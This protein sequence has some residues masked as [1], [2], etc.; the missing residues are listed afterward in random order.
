LW[1]IAGAA[2]PA[3]QGFNFG[4]AATARGAI[5]A[6][7][8]VDP[9][10]PIHDKAALP[11]YSDGDTNNLVA[12]NTTLQSGRQVNLVATAMT[13][14]AT[15]TLINTTAVSERL[16]TGEQPSGLNL[17]VHDSPISL[18]IFLGPQIANHTSPSGMIDDFCFVPV[19]L[20]LKA[21]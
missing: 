12:G 21:P 10:A 19:T 4:A 13:D 2:E 14:H 6:Y 7:R 18:G 8:G 16:N 15:Y 17:I 3:S 11:F 9:V 20:V 5:L 1:R